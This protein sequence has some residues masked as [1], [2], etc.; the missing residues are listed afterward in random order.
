MNTLVSLRFHSSL[1]IHISQKWQRSALV[2]NKTVKSQLLKTAKV[3]FSFMGGGDLL[4]II[5]PTRPRLTGHA[6]TFSI[7]MA[8][9][10]FGRLC[11]SN[12]MQHSQFMG[13]ASCAA[14]PDGTTWMKTGHTWHPYHQGFHCCLHTNI[15]LS[16]TCPI[17]H[18]YPHFQMY[19]KMMLWNCTRHFTS[20]SCATS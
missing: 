2:T 8:K 10:E 11:I 6:G 19:S 4:G 20:L 15:A 7:A 18:F 1:L 17:A 14:H 5:P 13:R 12:W 3:Y 9:R 16:Q